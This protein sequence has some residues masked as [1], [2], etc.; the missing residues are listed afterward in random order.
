MQKSW[1]VSWLLSRWCTCVRASGGGDGDEG[2][3]LE[4]FFFLFF[5]FRNK[6][7]WGLHCKVCVLNFVFLC[8]AVLYSVLRIRWC[9]GGSWLISAAPAGQKRRRS[10]WLSAVLPGISYSHH[11]RICKLTVVSEEGQHL[12]RKPMWLTTVVDSR[13]IPNIFIPAG[14]MTTWPELLFFYRQAVNP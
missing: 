2:R 10:V 7:I 1:G 13:I 11:E 8:F 4:L 12:L 9:W 5:L 6:G 3:D 14:H